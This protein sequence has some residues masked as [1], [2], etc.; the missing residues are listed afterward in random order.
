VLDT[1]RLKD[2]GEINRADLLAVVEPG[3]ITGEF[4][5]TV[6]GEGLFYP[7]DPN[8]L[9]TCCLGGN[10]AHN[11]GGP[12]AFKYGVTREYVMGLE[13]VLADGK[14]LDIGR[15]TI[16]CSAGY[17]MTGLFVGSEGTLGVFTRLR[18]RLIRNP[19][20]IMTLLVIFADEIAAGRA[21]SNIVE[22]GLVPRVMEFMDGVLVDILRRSGAQVVPAGAGALLLVEID[23]RDVDTV[24]AEAERLAEACEAQGALDVLVAKHGG[25]RSRLWSARRT[26][27]DAVKERARFKI[28]EDIAVPRSKASILLE[29]LRSIGEKRGVLIAS[30]GHAGDGNYHVNILWDDPEWDPEPTVKDVFELAIHLEGTITGEHGVGLAK[31]HYLPL[32]KNTRQL[33]IQKALK[34]L[35]DPKAL[36]NPGKIFIP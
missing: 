19:P 13:A 7:P 35:L 10:V 16:K 2:L 17:D 4:Q 15:R 31:K 5:A 36:L 1:S 8:S 18:L 32:E 22:A 25:D 29:K 28:A 9:E 26:L 33:G 11:A 3:M 27:S 12:R 21:V 20:E 6:E 23:G 34:D 14:L 30:Y 24:E